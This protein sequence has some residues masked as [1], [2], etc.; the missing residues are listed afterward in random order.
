MQDYYALAG[1]FAS[2]RVADRALG[3]SVDS[4]AVFEAHKNV[5]KWE[6]ELKKAETS[7]K[8]LVKPA[9]SAKPNKPADRS[10]EELDA[11]REQ[12]RGQLTVQIEALMA[13]IAEAKRTPGYDVPLAPGA[14]EGSLQVLAAVNT[15]GSR[16]TYSD[17]PVDAAVEIRGNPN[18][19]GEAV[20]RRFVAVLSPK[21]A[22][23]FQRGSG[24]YELAQTMFRSS[25]SL[26]ARVMVNRLWK[27][28]FG[29][30]LVDTP[31][32]FGTQGQ[33]PSHPALLD[34]LAGQF[35]D[36]GWSM[37]SVHRRLVL[38]ACYQQSTRQAHASEAERKSYAGL[39]IRRLEVEQ[40][41]DAM[42]VACDK[43]DWAIAG[44]P[45]E[46]SNVEHVRRTLYGTIRR[47]ELSDVLRLNDFPDPLTHSP[48]RSPTTT[49]LQQL[50][51][52]NSPFVEHWAGALVD[53]LDRQVTDLG[54][55]QLRITFAYRWIFGRMPT[56]K[57][58][59]LGAA[60]VGQGTGDRWRV[61]V[62][63]LMASNEFLFVD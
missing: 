11:E 45:A 7:R 35:I 63:A 37:K 21:N 14:M 38:S 10:I 3:S 52:L 17:A 47:R 12:K 15:H 42:L 46:L 55:A 2:T 39:P 13:K 43:I 54:N 57:E 16:L 59:R 8:A 23:R 22:P 60:F 56:D 36:S 29:T 18:K 5:T 62:Q 33:Q 41:R 58:L 31:S 40:W 49:P 34:D 50:Y 53:R 4:L 32:D 28:H 44:P 51:T 30:G 20:P 19:T 27:L 61:Y 25:Q 48:E 1:V 6:A 26:V 24:R 9:D